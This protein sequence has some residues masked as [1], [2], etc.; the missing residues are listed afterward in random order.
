MGAETT[1]Y[2]LARVSHLEWRS[3]SALTLTEAMD[4]VNRMDDVV[5]VLEARYE[6]YEPADTSTGG[7]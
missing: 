2:V 5:D 1:V 4:K 6:P 7:V 3:V